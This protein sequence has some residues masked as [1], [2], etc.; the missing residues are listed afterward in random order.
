MC[1][2]CEWVGRK[3]LVEVEKQQREVD[4]L[5]DQYSFAPKDTQ[6]DL[7]H[8][9]ERQAYAI[10]GGIFHAR[11]PDIVNE[12]L[13]R[14]WKS[15]G[16]F[17]GDS[18]FSTWFHRIVVNV[19]KQHGAKETAR[20]KREISLE[21]LTHVHQWCLGGLMGVEIAQA[22]EALTKNENAFLDDVLLPLS[23]AEVA[24]KWGLSASGVRGRW[25][26]I[27]RKIKAAL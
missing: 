23:D 7:I 27:K 2:L 17:R 14:A 24:T 12:S 21:S 18:K 11:R 25:M 5:W 10:A 20:K 1:V 6:N 19:C 3:K 9:L 13:T 22:R 26:R 8:A 4:K 16:K 15:M